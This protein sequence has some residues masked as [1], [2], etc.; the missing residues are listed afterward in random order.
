VN[1]L[2]ADLLGGSIDKNL[3]EA[4]LRKRS[5]VL[6]NLIALRKVRIEVVFARPLR[7]RIHSAIQA[8]CRP[9][10]K[11]DRDAIEDRQRSRKSKT[12]RHVFMFETS[13]SSNRAKEF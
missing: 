11:G 7:L 5:I 2:N 4:V 10:R 6:R 8:Q 9:N 1:P 13:T 3:D 12:D